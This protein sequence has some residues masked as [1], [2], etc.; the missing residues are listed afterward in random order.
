MTIEN[1]VLKGKAEVEIS[2]YIKIDYLYAL[3]DAPSKS[4]VLE[5]YN[6]KFSKG[7]NSFLIS[8]LLENNKNEY[9]KGLNVT[10]DF[11][12]SNHSKVLGNEIYI[13]LNLNKKALELRTKKRE[14]ESDR[15]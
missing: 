7:N 4:K 13:N 10:Y 11:T 12:I 3:E 2:G 14:K 8:N 15:A 9:D 1:A 5:F 6:S